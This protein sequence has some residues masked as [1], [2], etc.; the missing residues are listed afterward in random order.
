MMKKIDKSAIEV[1][2]SNVLEFWANHYPEVGRAAES[3][4]L[5]AAGRFALVLFV[6]FL[7]NGDTLNVVMSK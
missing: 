2:E 6:L 3:G 5:S 7:E 4:D 1:K